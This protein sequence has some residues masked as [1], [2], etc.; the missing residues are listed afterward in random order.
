MALFALYTLY[1]RIFIIFSVEINLL[2][3]LFFPVVSALLKVRIWFSFFFLFFCY[4]GGGCVIRV[5]VLIA[6]NQ[7]DLLLGV[8]WIIDYFQ[9]IRKGPTWDRN[10]HEAWVIDVTAIVHSLAFP[11]Y[12]RMYPRVHFTIGHAY[13]HTFLDTIEYMYARLARNGYTSWYIG[14]LL[15]SMRYRA[16]FAARSVSR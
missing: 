7:S 13:G 3:N 12:S 15:Y 5:A 8:H 11:Q 2:G 6:V 10:S 16:D 9:Q 4:K 1:H 14:Y